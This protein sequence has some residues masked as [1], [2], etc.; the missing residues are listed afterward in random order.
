VIDAARSA[1]T[2]SSNDGVLVIKEL[3]IQDAETG[4]ISSKMPQSTFRKESTNESSA[5]TAK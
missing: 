3:I 2:S 1:D 5:K 4:K